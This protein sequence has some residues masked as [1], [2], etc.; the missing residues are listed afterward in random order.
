MTGPAARGLGRKRLDELKQAI[1]LALNHWPGDEGSGQSVRSDG[2][3]VLGR[4]RMRRAFDAM[5]DI[6]AA[7]AARG[8]HDVGV[9]VQS[10]INRAN[11]NDLDKR[12]RW[13]KVIQ[14]VWPLVFGEDL[15]P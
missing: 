3:A 4:E 5:N 7:A 8:N 11:T 6:K 15:G 10:V 9:L 13:S 14:A 1:E 12:R 2:V